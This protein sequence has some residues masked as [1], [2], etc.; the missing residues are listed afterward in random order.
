MLRPARPQR[1]GQ[2]DDDRD[3]GRADRAGRRRGRASSGRRWGERRAG[4]PRAARRLAPGDAGSP[5]SSRSTRRSSSSAPSTDGARSAEQLLAELS[6]EEK[7]DAR[8][9][10]LSGGQRQRL[11]VA[12]ALVGDPEILFL[13]EPTTGLDPQSRLQLWEHDR[14]LPARPDGTVLLT[15]HYM[16]E[17]ERL[18]DRVAIVD[19]GQIIAL[20]TPAELIALA[21]GAA[22]VD[23][24]LS[25]PDV[26]EAD[27]ARASRASASTAADRTGALPSTRSPR[28]C[29]PLLAA[30]ERLGRAARQLSTHRATLE[31]VFVSL[32]GRELAMSERAQRSERSAARADRRP[33]SREFLREPEAVFW[34][35]A[36]PVLLAVVLGFA[37]RE[38]PPD[39]IPVGVVS[40]AGS[41]GARSPR[42]SRRRR[43]WS[44]RDAYPTRRRAR[45]ACARA[46]S[47]CSSR[48]GPAA[49][50]PLRRDAPRRAH[51]APGSATTPSSAPPA[52]RT[53]SPRASG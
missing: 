5:R 29:P 45:R 30:V 34:V 41:D 26:D 16:D 31:D 13:D 1:R 19:H 25:E 24:I 15:T 9:G 38:R 53:R 50:L 4:A 36:F 10:K 35:F 14:G 18:C 39:P 3:P 23:R 2:D 8:V 22:N 37:F 47:R 48:T 46:R 21:A 12:C 17:A 20:G 27:S 43:H 40:G 42:R 7:R 28:P 49:R 51:R 44:G 33:R 32:T 11:A 52:A 6:L